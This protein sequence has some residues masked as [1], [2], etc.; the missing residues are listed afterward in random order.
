MYN[1]KLKEMAK[2]QIKGKIGILFIINL[3]V[4][5]ISWIA[6]TVL[7]LIP[8]VGPIVY[9]VLIA[10]AFAL[11]ITKIYLNIAKGNKPVAGDALR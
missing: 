10:P 4:F 1:S 6:A 2:Q 3:I 8:L 11:S 5:V 9:S 7:S